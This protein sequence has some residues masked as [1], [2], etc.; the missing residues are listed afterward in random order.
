MRGRGVH[1]GFGKPEGTRPIGR[2]RRKWEDNIKLDH[3][4]I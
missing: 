2:L 4:K 1:E 3:R